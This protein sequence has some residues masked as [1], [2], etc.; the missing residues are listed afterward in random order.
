[1]STLV[2]SEVDLAKAE[3]TTGLKV[4]GKGA[5]ML[6][7]AAFVALLGLIFLFHTLAYVLD[8][9]L[10]LSASYGIVTALLLL[11]AAILALLG[12]KSVSSAKPKP[13]QAIAEAQKTVAAVKSSV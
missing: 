13:E 10:P 2:R 12:K 11:I 1:M 8:I 6:G 3:V 9:W 5:G 7:A 4:A